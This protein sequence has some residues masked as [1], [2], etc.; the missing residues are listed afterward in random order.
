MSDL[1]NPQVELLN[2]EEES[3]DFSAVLESAGLDRL[4]IELIKRGYIDENFALYVSERSDLSV[5][6]AALTFVLTVINPNRPDPRYRFPAPE[7]DIPGVL[8]EAG[9]AFLRDRRALNIQVVDHL[10]AEDRPELETLTLLLA[11]A[12][13]TDL[14]F[15]DAYVAEGQRAREVIGKVAGQW[16]DVFTYLIQEGQV[17]RADLI[18]AALGGADARR[19]YQT[20]PVVA[21]WINA[22]GSDLTSITQTSSITSPETVAAVLEQLQVHPSNM[23][24]YAPDLQAELIERHQ[25]TITRHNL[26]A[27][28]I[29]DGQLPS[30]DELFTSGHHDE[31]FA[32][33]LDHLQPYLR[34]CVEDG[35]L[36]IKNADLY[37]AVI[38]SVGNLSD[39]TSQLTPGELQDLVDRAPK[40]A[41]VRDLRDVSEQIWP[42]L[43]RAGRVVASVGNLHEY[44]KQGVGAA[45]DW[46][47]LLEQ[48]D[49]IEYAPGDSDQTKAAVA[50][51]VLGVAG[52]SSDR[53]LALVR[54]L[55]LG[56]PI[57]PM[58]LNDAG[59][60]LIPELL[61]AAIIAESLEA[62]LATRVQ[63]A[64]RRRYVEKA[65]QMHTYL[66]EIPDLS[67]EELVE[68]ADSATAKTVETV[69]NILDAIDNL[70]CESARKLTEA[71]VRHQLQVPY[72]SLA[73]LAAH[74]DDDCI[75][76]LELLTQ[77]VD[78]LTDG[79]LR[80]LLA[81]LPDPYCNFGKERIETIPLRDEALLDQLASRNIITRRRKPRTDLFIVDVP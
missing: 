57:D 25:Y 36:V 5:T 51:D 77:H 21:D 7:K 33:V 59:R 79:E 46:S 39:L 44:R 70:A 50:S 4:T 11:E 30:L 58:G 75:A 53:R 37:V 66:A 28:A 74:V 52:I 72:E 56:T 73:A 13:E 34:L 32:H 40:E 78:H 47:Q 31:V 1:I 6:P 54:S 20:S 42:A 49:K 29:G 35:A 22:N 67:D 3:I 16:D 12:T 76:F 45:D 10:V 81:S 18:D 24:R 26:T 43:T 63:S 23:Q 64:T 80:S 69:L 19:P 2:L 65:S 14:S 62:Y 71:A 48:L 61:D 38:N 15:L 68:I 8:R 41:H 55:Q 17:P 60:D 9:E 27:S